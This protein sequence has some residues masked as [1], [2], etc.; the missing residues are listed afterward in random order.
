VQCFPSSIPY[1]VYCKISYYCNYD[2]FTSANSLFYAPARSCAMPNRF[3]RALT[4]ALFIRCTYAHTAADKR[5][6]SI[7]CLIYIHTRPTRL[8][9]PLLPNSRF[10]AHFYTLPYNIYKIHNFTPNVII[11]DLPHHFPAADCPHHFIPPRFR[12][13]PPSFV[14]SIL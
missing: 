4:H 9:L 11:R 1:N 12:S 5:R 3:A 8:R 6:K 10:C 14:T 7:L 13:S 2:I